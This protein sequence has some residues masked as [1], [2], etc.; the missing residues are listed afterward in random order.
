M[1]RLIA[2]LDQKSARL[3]LS[4]FNYRLSQLA[5]VLRKLDNA[6]KQDATNLGDWQHLFKIE[7]SL[8]PAGQIRITRIPL[9]LF[10]DDAPSSSV[11]IIQS[12]TIMMTLASAS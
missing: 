1:D 4:F 5:E 11:N 7:A 9:S 8:L 3:Y 2:Y 12:L 6:V 10:Q